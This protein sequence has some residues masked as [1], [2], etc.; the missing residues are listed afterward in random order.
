MAGVTAGWLG[1]YAW[2]LGRAGAVF[3]RPAV[4]RR[5]ERLTGI[6]LIGFA[7]RLALA[8]A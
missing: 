4:G 6:V 5:I 2:L 7:A 8:R 3:Q 1:C